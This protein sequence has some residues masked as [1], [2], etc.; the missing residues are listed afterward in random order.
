MPGFKLF[1]STM[2]GLRLANLVFS[3]TAL[4]LFMGWTWR[5]LGWAEALLAGVLLASDPAFFF[6][7]ALDWGSLLP[8]LLCRLGGF[9]LVLQAWRRRHAGW[10]LAAGL[11]LGL[12][13]FNKLDF[14]IILAG[15]TLAALG[16]Y[17]RALTTA[18]RIRPKMILLG[19]LGFLA[20]AAPVLSLLRVI[21]AAIQSPGA[22]R[23]PGELVEKCHTLCAMY[24]GSYFY[25]LMDAGG[26]FDQMYQTPPPVWTPL[27]FLVL[28]AAIVLLAD[29]LHSPPESPVRRNRVFILFSAGLITLGAFLLPDAV[30]LH[31]TALVYPFPH[32]L[33]AA[34]AVAVWRRAGRFRRPGFRRAALALVAGLLLMAA[35]ANG[36][37]LRRT[38]QLIQETGGRGWWSG[39]LARFAGEVQGR[40]D[41]TIRSLDWGF[42][43]Q[44]EFLTRGP[45]LAEPFWQ[46]ILGQTPVWPRD[47]QQVYLAHPAEFSLSPLS[48]QFMESLRAS[49]N[50][51]VTPWRDRQG[52]VAFY[53]ITFTA[54]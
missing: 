10:A 50:A 12:G 8:S 32:L 36:L 54:R 18:F 25:R 41:L 38:G 37:A 26:R 24:D 44:L 43:E 14:G 22:S 5:L 35:L 42:N 45:R 1:G 7:G 33:I 52:R 6:L 19:L 20:G 39:A 40:S 30:R 51:L 49:T 17:G 53:S 9:L 29:I 23:H 46:E 3:A 31:H 27:G 47:A 34:A 4:L 16:A 11:V 15:T 21:L 13:V 2:A 28:I 48:G